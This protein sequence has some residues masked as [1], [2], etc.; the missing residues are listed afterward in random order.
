M[1]RSESELKTAFA[2]E[3]IKYP[4]DPFKAACVVFGSDTGKALYAAS[5]WVY[6]A[7]VIADK[8]R[9]SA[10]YNALEYMPSKALLAKAIWDLATGQDGRID[11][12]NKIKAF[13]LY[14]EVMNFIEKPVAVSIDNSKNVTV[15][16]VMV[17]RE[18]ASNEEWEQKLI[19]QQARLLDAS[20]NHYF[21][22]SH[23][24]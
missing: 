3:W 5:H 21:I 16:K 11:A 18:A 23:V 6:D 24:L 9:I 19:T 13:K 1:D 14:G 8:E 17:V 22:N 12:D 20:A 15:N 4:T 7:Q 2:E 10:D